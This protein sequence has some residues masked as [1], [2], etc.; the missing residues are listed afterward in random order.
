MTNRFDADAW[1]RGADLTNATRED[2][3]TQTFAAAQ[4][5]AV[6]GNDSIELD[7][8]VGEETEAFR[9]KWYDLIG[10]LGAR[11]GSDYS[12]MKATAD[13]YSQTEEDAVAANSRFWEPDE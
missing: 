12:K 9:L 13:N 3:E 6:T 10:N 7:R 1:N 5:S 4:A 11:L 8:V 2:W